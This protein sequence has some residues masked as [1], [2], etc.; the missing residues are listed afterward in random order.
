MRG[1]V[2]L[3]ATTE[4]LRLAFK[5]LKN[6]G[7]MHIKRNIVEGPTGKLPGNIMYHIKNNPNEPR[8]LANMNMPKAVYMKGNVDDL[9]RKGSSLGKL[10]DKKVDG[11]TKK[12]ANLL[13]LMH[14]ANEGK[15]AAKGETTMAGSML[16]HPNV[17]QIIGKESNMIAAGDK[18]LKR[19]GFKLK[20]VRKALGASRPFNEEDILKQVLPVNKDGKTIKFRY[21]KTKLNRRMREEMMKKEFGLPVTENRAAYKKMLKQVYQMNKRSL[22]DAY[23]E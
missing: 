11:K 3:S 16:G 22:K 1:L 15:S 4:E 21:G 14:E 6:D 9:I 8:G 13:T 10:T 7:V 18:E 12:A 23:G 17:S 5:Q 20:R 2:K 19:A